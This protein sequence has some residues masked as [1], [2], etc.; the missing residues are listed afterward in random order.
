[1]NFSFG[2]TVTI[3]RPT[4]RSRPGDAG[5]DR[6]GD[7]DESLDVHH[8]IENVG[9]DRSGTIGADE[10]QGMGERLICDVVLYCPVGS[11]VLASDRV[12]LEDD[13]AVYSVVARPVNWKSPFTGWNPGL[14]VKLKAVT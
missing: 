14:V 2:E 12:E 8:T 6:S 1:M 4:D 13:D 7:R 5:R 10:P 9:V 11:D 3:L